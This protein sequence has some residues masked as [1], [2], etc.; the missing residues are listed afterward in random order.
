[1][2]CDGI[3]G[4]GKSR[5]P[6]AAWS[7]TASAHRRLPPSTGVARQATWPARVDAGA[8]VVSPDMILRWSRRLIAQSTT[9]VLED[10]EAAP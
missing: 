5:P 2:V 4:D 1:M 10:G 6:P 3:A 8:R 7:S 9:A